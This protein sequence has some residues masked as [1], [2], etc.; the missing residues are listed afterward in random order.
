MPIQR[1]LTCY[2][3]NGFDWTRQIICY[4]DC[5][6]GGRAFDIIR[7]YSVPVLI[8][9]LVALFIESYYIKQDGFAMQALYK[10][11]GGK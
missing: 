8:A 1:I 9:F 3:K 6:D 11:L 7:R 4:T 2:H 10:L 5:M